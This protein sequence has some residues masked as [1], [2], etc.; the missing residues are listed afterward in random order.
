M[1]GSL[2]LAPTR[3]EIVCSV[4]RRS[5]PWFSPEIFDGVAQSAAKCYVN[6]LREYV[7][8]APRGAADVRFNYSVKR[9]VGRSVI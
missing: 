6:K 3:S 9:S 4:N 1:W 8:R 2:R 7:T 5:T